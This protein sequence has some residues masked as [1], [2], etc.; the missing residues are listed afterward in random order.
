MAILLNIRCL[1]VLST[2]FCLLFAKNLIYFIFSYVDHLWWFS[3]IFFSLSS[4]TFLLNDF[5]VRLVYEGLYSESKSSL[6]YFFCIFCISL[7]L[8]IIIYQLNHIFKKKIYQAVEICLSYRFHRK[9][10]IFIKY[11]SSTYI[12]L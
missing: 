6:I 7:I 5:I 3:P 12:I 8:K 11:F 9:L 4:W 2:N 10:T 1:F